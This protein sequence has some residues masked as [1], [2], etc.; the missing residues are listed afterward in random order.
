[1]KEEE[2]KSLMAVLPSVTG[3]LDGPA[4]KDLE[5]KMRSLQEEWVKTKSALENRVELSKTYVKFHSNAAEVGKELDSLEEQF[6]KKDSV[7]EETLK[8]TEERWLTIRQLYVQLSH[9]GRNFMEDSEKV[10]L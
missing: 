5:D 4:R 3:Q 2:L 10:K 6:R 1:M 9:I 8:R 7:S